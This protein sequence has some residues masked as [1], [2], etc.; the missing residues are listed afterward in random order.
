MEYF[1]DTKYFDEDDLPDILPLD[2]GEN[3]SIDEGN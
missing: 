3:S 1:E 2:S